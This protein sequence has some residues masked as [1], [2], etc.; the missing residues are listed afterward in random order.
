MGNYVNPS[1]VKKG[2]GSAEGKSLLITLIDLS[3][4]SIWPGRDDNKVKMLGNIV[5]KAGKYMTQIEVTP[6]K[7]NLPLGSEGEE[8]NASLNSLPEFV[9]PGSTL[10]I[11]ELFANWLG[12]SVAVLVRVGACDGNDAFYRTYGTPCAPLSLFPEG[13]NDND[14]TNSMLKFQQFAKTDIMPGRYYG[15]LTL[16]TVN[17]VAADTVNVDV[18]AGDGQYQLVDN[19]G[20]TVITDLINAVTGGSYTLLGS[21]GGNPAT[22]EASNVNFL[23]AG[24]VDWQGL[25]GASITFKAYDAGGGDHVL[26]EQ[27]RSV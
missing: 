20:A 9:Y 25:A 12:R 7:T 5:M 18:A 26:I 17:N 21:G 22:I 19:T 8:D 10:D 27:S 24:A 2:R 14:A 16:D 4:V 1:L 23:L 11:E 6:S 13:Q 15:T 3:D